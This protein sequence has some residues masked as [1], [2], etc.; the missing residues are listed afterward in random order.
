MRL[1]DLIDPEV[2]YELFTEG[3]IAFIDARPEASYREAR[4][5]LPQ[6][7]H[8]P[9]GHGAEIVAALRALPYG[10]NIGLVM[11]C[12][13]P[14]QAASYQ[15]ARYAKE[16]GFGDVSVLAGGYSAWADAGFPF[17]PTPHSIP[18]EEPPPAPSAL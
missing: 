9:A 4:F 14:H 8:V 1:P 11:Y 6:A 12:D 15:V 5:Q 2:A 10:T 3:R 13:E 18:I 7:I 16:V 17:E